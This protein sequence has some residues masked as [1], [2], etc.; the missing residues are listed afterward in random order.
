MKDDDGDRRLLEMA[1]NAME[2]AYSP[3]SGVKV[4]AVVLGA[5][6]Q[7]YAGCNVENATLGLSVCAERV[8]LF[9]AR[10]HGTMEIQAIVFTSNHPKVTSPCGACRQ[11]MLELAPNARVL[12]GDETGVKKE[13]ASPLDLLPDAFDGDWK[14]P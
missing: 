8:A 10:A 11:V 7:V 2:R 1:R 5:D 9:H 12:Y 14:A 6:G 13:W 3:Y 4:G